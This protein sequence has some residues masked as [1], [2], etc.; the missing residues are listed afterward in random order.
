MHGIEFNEVM[1]DKEVGAFGKVV[2]ALER[3]YEIATAKMKCL[4]G[5]RSDASEFVDL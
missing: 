3:G 5:I 2:E 1:P 4:A